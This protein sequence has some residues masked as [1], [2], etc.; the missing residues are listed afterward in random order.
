VPGGG[1]AYIKGATSDAKLLEFI[2]SH[3]GDAQWVASV[4]TGAFVLAEAKLLETLRA[5]THWSY[6]STFQKRYPNVQ[7]VNGFPRFVADGKFVTG[8]GISSGIDLALTMAGR[9]AGDPVGR[10]IELIIQY[11]PQPPYGVGDPSVADFDT[12]KQVITDLSS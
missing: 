12:Y 3:A 4:C 6:L 7:V 8:G 1:D 10:Q 2:R 9:I 5:T 11:R